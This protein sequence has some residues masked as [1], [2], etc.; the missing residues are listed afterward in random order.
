[1]S[2]KFCARVSCGE[3]ASALLLINARELAAHLV[4]LG[5]ETGVV[6]VPLCRGHSDAVIVPVGWTQTDSRSPVEEADFEPELI[7]ID[8]DPSEPPGQTGAHRLPEMEEADEDDMDEA[9]VGE[10]PP[11]LSRAFRAAGLD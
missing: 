7:L 3:P 5:E 4:D 1:M 10:I 11:L 9:A 2:A 6:G 8:E